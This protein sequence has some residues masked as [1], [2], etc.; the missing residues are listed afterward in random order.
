MLIRPPP[1]RGVFFPP[2]AVPRINLAHR[3]AGT[4]Q[5]AYLFGHGAPIRLLPGY[6]PLSVKSGTPSR[7][8]GR[9]GAYADY[10]GSSGHQA[11]GNPSG[12]VSIVVVGMRG[13]TAGSAGST[14]M[15]PALL[16]TVDPSLSSGSWLGM[17]IEV[18]N[19][20]SGT[21]D[22]FFV[23][24][25]PSGSGSVTGPN[26]IWID[27]RKDSTASITSSTDLV[28]GVWYCFGTTITNLPA[29]NNAL[30]FGQFETGIFTLTGGIAAVFFW[31]GVL[32]DGVMADLTANPAGILSWPGDDLPLLSR[33]GGNAY[34][35][36]L[37]A[38]N[39]A[40]AGQVVA[41]RAGRRLPLSAGSIVLTG[42]DLALRFGR[43]L[44]LATGSVALSGQ[45]VALLL[46]RRLGLS[47]GAVTLSGQA[48][49]LRR[50]Y[51]LAAGT[52]TF[53]LSGQAMALRADRRLALL[54]GGFA[55][56]G[57]TASLLRGRRLAAGTGVFAVAGQSVSLLR[58]YLLAAGVGAFALTGHAVSLIYSNARRLPA[59][60]T[61]TLRPRWRSTR[62]TAPGVPT[63]RG[64]ADPK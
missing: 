44:P 40:L 30:T 17:E 22:R 48:V 15:V 58:G 23:Q 38:G 63:L 57:Q 7:A 4:L 42:Q 46:G 32:P 50:G 16:S 51:S 56:S 43:R 13:I 2:G 41:L 9:P 53:A 27:G 3:A 10:N 21:R 52:G 34:T 1:R 61:R 19:D 31:R 6:G 39:F 25:Y 28:N 60:A 18:G 14:S 11:T 64:P 29:G 37:A 26:A 8:I 54:A 49:T 45:P 35:L 62:L 24:I 55:L 33:V 5:A 12:D 47:V 59:G 36:P 20:W